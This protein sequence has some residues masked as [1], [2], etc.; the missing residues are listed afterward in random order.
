M[1]MVEA[2]ANWPYGMAAK[3]MNPG[4]GYLASPLCHLLALCL[5]FP[6]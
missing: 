2:T 5:N 3:S 6:V 4:V 1:H